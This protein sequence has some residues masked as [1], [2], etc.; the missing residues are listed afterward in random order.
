MFELNRFIYSW[1]SFHGITD[2]LLP[3]QSWFPYYSIVPLTLY[4]P[5]NILNFG[6]ILLSTYHF[7]QDMPLS[8][9]NLL[10]LLLIFIFLGEYKFSQNLF[11]LFMCF[12]H[13]PIHLYQL[14]YNIYSISLLSSTFVLFYNCDTLIFTIKNIVESGGRKPNNIFHKLILGIINAHIL[15]NH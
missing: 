3:F 6:T 14:T 2:L 12:I 15:A 7:S 10:L 5:I 8:F 11:I 13:V 4:V 1:I 9:N